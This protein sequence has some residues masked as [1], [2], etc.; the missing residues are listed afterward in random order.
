MEKNSDDHQGK[1]GFA[2]R[3]NGKSL[4]IDPRGG[5]VP[6]VNLPRF[7]D[8]FADQARPELRR[9]LQDAIP[10]MMREFIDQQVKAIAAKREAAIAEFMQR[11]GLW[12]DQIVLREWW[13]NDT[14]HCQIY[15]RSEMAVKP[16]ED[17]AQ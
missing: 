1:P 12:P 3:R 14:Y 13:E 10:D 2:P 15:A 8:V 9:A 4:N 5:L 6:N 16:S 11:T 7:S 17:P